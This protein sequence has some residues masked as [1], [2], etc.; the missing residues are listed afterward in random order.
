[1][2]SQMVGVSVTRAS[3]LRYQSANRKRVCCRK[4]TS[5]SLRLWETEQ[6]LAYSISKAE[7]EM[8]QLSA[9]LAE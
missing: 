7:L 9:N 3:H 4:S 8:P 6:S 5:Y 2:R 1:M